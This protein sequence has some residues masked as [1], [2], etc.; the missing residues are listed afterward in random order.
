MFDLRRE[1]PSQWEKFLKPANPADP[2]VFAFTMS[3]DL[4]LARDG[5]NI[6]KINSIRLLARCS[7]PGEYA[8]VMTPPAPDQFD[9]GTTEFTLAPLD[10]YGGL[11]SDLKAVTGL[12]VTVD[13]A[14]PAVEWQLQMT[15]PN[16]NLQPDLANGGME[17]AEMFLVLG[18][19]WE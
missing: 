16:G 11:H 13:P 7:D 9:D 3:P 10:Q 18:Y 14:A 19:Q 2:N 12:D 15:G 5:G 4:F 17:V 6:L 1:F 8:V